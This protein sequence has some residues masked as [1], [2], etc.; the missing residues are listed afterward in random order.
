LIK[1]KNLEWLQGTLMIDCIS[2][3]GFKLCC[4][5]WFSNVQSSL[6]SI[7][8]EYSETMHKLTGNQGLILCADCLV[9][10]VEITLYDTTNPKNTRRFKHD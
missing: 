1:L 4:V 8:P 5:D 3:F 6:R 7:I 9:K 10:S 2:D